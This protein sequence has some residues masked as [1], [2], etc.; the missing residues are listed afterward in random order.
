MYTLVVIWLNHLRVSQF[1]AIFLKIPVTQINPETP[2][3]RLSTI[4]FSGKVGSTV[5]LPQVSLILS[6]ALWVHVKKLQKIDILWL[7]VL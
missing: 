2:S 4:A 1:S 7:V 5:D 3:H 6:Q